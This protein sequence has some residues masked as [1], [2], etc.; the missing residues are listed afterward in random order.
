MKQPS[1]GLVL[2]GGGARGLAHIGVLRVLE[3]EGITIDCL[4]GT[5]MG[6][7]IAAGYSAGMSSYI[8]EREAHA[9]T[10]KRAFVHLV[11]PCLPDG[12]I[13]RGERVLEYFKK[14][15]GGKTFSELALPLALVAVDLNS[16]K[17]VIIQE[18]SVALALR[19]TISVPCLFKPVE[20]NDKKLIDGG[21][22]NNIPVDIVKKMGADI[23]IAVN[24]GLT[25]GGGVGQ[26]I[27]NHRFVP[28]N[29]ANTLN[30]L[31]DTVFTL[32]FVEQSN[33]LKQFPPDIM[34]TPAIPISINTVAGYD[35]VT[36]LIA[37]GERAAEER[38]AEIKMLIK[39]QPK[40]FSGSKM[41]CVQKYQSQSTYVKANEKL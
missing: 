26:W 24:V 9:A 30:V 8:L 29:L 33:K 11:D 25:R 1:V 31:D 18:G 21:V 32:R 28:N 36:D 3:R 35:R 7:V 12:G 40:W 22:L 5:S 20:I 23:V 10:R 39:S 6:G 37:A 41:V 4:A 19:A 16:H 27:G 17:E 13:I 2:S 34:I 14:E 38:I 15:F